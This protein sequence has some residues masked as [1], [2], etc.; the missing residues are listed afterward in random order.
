[1][2][3]YTRNS[4]D[5]AKKIRKQRKKFKITQAEL[6]GMVDCHENTIKQWETW[7]SHISTDT[8]IKIQ[9]ALSNVEPFAIAT[10]RE[11]KE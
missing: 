4:H 6:A 5:L 1:M 8:L 10:S 3:I 9:I 11:I 7:K 2:I